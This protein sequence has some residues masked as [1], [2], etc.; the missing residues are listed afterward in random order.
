MEFNA[1]ETAIV[2]SAPEVTKGK[3]IFN[4]TTSQLTQYKKM[5]I[6]CS[7][8]ICYSRH[9]FQENH[10]TNLVHKAIR[11]K[12]KQF[13]NCNFRSHSRAVKI[14]AASNIFL[15]FFLFFC[16]QDEILRHGSEIKRRFYRAIF[17]QRRI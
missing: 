13:S 14:G 5:K 9:N 2:S 7:F 8:L 6:A 10:Y 11:R 15:F 16:L 4:E 12:V 17:H 1:E 3:M